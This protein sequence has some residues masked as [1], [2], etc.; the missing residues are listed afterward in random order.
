MFI[1]PMKP[2]EAK[3]NKP[4]NSKHHIA[5]QK[6]DGVRVIVSQMDR[7]YVYTKNQELITHKF[8]ELLQ[9]P[10][11]EGTVLDGELMV[12]D[13]QG[14]PDFEAMTARYYSRKNL[15]PVVF[16]AFDILRYKGIDVTHLPLLKRKQYLDEAFT[17]TAS[18]KKIPIYEGSTTS[19]FEEICKQ[20]LEGIVIK[21]IKDNS[22]YQQGKRSQAW[23]KVTNWTHADVYVSGYRKNN[24]AL[25]ASIDGPN[26]DKLP[27]GVIE[28]G[29][30]PEHRLAIEQVKGRLVY[31][32][33]EHFAY[34]EPVIM[35]SIKT[36]AWSRSG[37][38][39]SPVFEA[40]VI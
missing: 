21:S 11:P 39:R 4:F 16:Y 28:H 30:K 7:L 20:G 15:R 10:L 22:V 40:F 24:F 33:D 27:V 23:Q 25:L 35:A 37:R 3:N 5:E 38:L 36:K 34:M 32:E 8:P 1:A 13:D 31:K 17:E 14:K 12:L 26:G 18:Y 19:Y 9:C 29:V 6:L 2:Y